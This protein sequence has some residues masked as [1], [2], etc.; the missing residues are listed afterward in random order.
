MPYVTLRDGAKLYYEERGQ[1]SRYI[2]TARKHIDH[3]TSIAEE[4]ATLGYHVLDIQLRGFGRSSRLACAYENVRN[5]WAQDIYEMAGL[6]GIRRFAYTG[7]SH[8][9][10]VGW[11]MLYQHPHCMVA[12]A[13]IVSAPRFSD[14]GFE[15]THPKGMIANKLAVASS[16]EGWH[17]LCQNS[18]DQAIAET[19]SYL[20]QEWK[21]RLKRCAAERMADSLAED[22]EER[23]L[24]FGRYLPQLDTDEK[25]EQWFRSID[26]PVVIQ[27]GLRDKNAPPEVLLRAARLIPGCVLHYYND[28]SHFITRTHTQQV[29]ATIHTY[30]SIRRVFEEE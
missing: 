2:L 26:I 30:F 13:P 7:M 3:Y 11:H 9:A 1:G 4:L 19:P 15:K 6:L 14:N 23:V 20:P 29:A 25:L 18:Y 24:D 21:D 10:S 5:Q 27:G 22:L 28:G 16:P 17:A 8:G 12:F